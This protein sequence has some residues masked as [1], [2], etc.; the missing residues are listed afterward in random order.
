MATEPD[1]TKQQLLTWVLG[2]LGMIASAISLVVGKLWWTSESHSKETKEALENAN[3]ALR[4]QNLGLQRELAQA[5]QNSSDAREA[6]ARLKGEFKATVVALHRAQ[7]WIDPTSTIGG[8]GREPDER[9]PTGVFYVEA[10]HRRRYFMGEA[11]EA[12][13]RER[14]RQRS[15]NPGA[16]RCERDRIDALSRKYLDSSTPPHR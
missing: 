16:D 13:L 2:A 3:A 5:Q 8:I 10:H 12:E 4:E 14:E 1:A 9:E 15:L 7:V 6:Y 11:A